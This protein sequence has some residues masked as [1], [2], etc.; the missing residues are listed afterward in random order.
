MAESHGFSLTCVLVSGR[1]LGFRVRSSDRQLPVSLWPSGLLDSSRQW[2]SHVHL[3][4]QQK[5][6]LQH[7]FQAGW[8]KLG[9]LQASQ[10]CH[11]HSGLCA[12]KE[13]QASDP[14]RTR[15]KAKGAAA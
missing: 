9:L 8:L 7:V 4:G 15:S 6:I 11:V 5:G 14:L 1:A 10:I 2:L 3:C 13:T 12:A